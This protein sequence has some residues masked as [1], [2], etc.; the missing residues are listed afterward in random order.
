MTHQDQDSDKENPSS[1]RWHG[2][3][4]PKLRAPLQLRSGMK[5]K[6]TALL[7]AKRDEDEITY[8]D[9]D[10]RFGNSAGHSFMADIDK[11][12]QDIAE[13]KRENNEMKWEND[14]MKRENDKMKQGN[15]EMK[16]DISDLKREGLKIR[17][18]ILDTFSPGGRDKKMV[19]E[20][21]AVA[22]G[23]NIRLD[24]DAIMEMEGISTNIAD[25]W[26]QAFLTIY[27]IKYPFLY[28][29]LASLDR[30]SSELF[31]IRATVKLLDRWGVSSQEQVKEDITQ[32]CNFCLSTWERWCETGTLADRKPSLS[33]NFNHRAA[34]AKTAY[35]VNY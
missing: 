35:M 13:M 8:D 19:D 5:D 32:D 21:N 1:T 3:V 11:M 10:V 30:N 25:G 26:K 20:R 18:A 9:D 27:E 7:L 28:Q 12:K 6:M 14:K 34:K 2:V 15:D 24:V 4:S 22:H 31:D 17:R 33:G 16:R 23:G 29:H